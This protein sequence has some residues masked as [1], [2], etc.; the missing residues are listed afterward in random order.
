MNG[1]L[2]VQPTLFL[3]G[4]DIGTGPIEDAF[5]DLIVHDEQVDRDIPV[6]LCVVAAEVSI[7]SPFGQIVHWL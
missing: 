5:K 4:R 1:S 2:S 7:R 6:G 3:L